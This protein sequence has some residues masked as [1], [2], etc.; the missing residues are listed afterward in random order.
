MTNSLPYAQD[1][2]HAL[3]SAGVEKGYD[4]RLSQADKVLANLRQA[5]QRGEVPLFALPGRR[6]DI[7][8]AMAIVETLK[9]DTSDL[10]I[11][12]TGGSGLSGQALAQL[13]GWGTPGYRPVEGAPHIHF[14][15]NLDAV[16]MAQAL[17]QMDLRTTRFLAISK[18]GGTAETLMQVLT[19]MSALEA[20]GGGKY[21]KHHFAVLTESAGDGG[22]NPLR[23]LAQAYDFP[24]LDH[25]PEIGG[26]YAVLSNVGMVPALLFGL[27]PQALRAGAGTVLASLLDGTSARDLAPA[28]GAALSL[29]LAEEAG[30]TATIIT[31]YADRLSKFTY[32]V[33]QLWAESLGKQGKGTL[34]VAGLGP[35]DQHSQ[36]QLYLD[37]PRDKFFTILTVADRASCPTVDET[38]ARAAGMADFAGRTMDE[39]VN[40]EAKATTDTLAARGCP[41]RSLTLPRLDEQSLGALFMHFML[42]TVI[43]AGLMNVDP[44]NQPAVE[45]AK[46]LAKKYLSEGAR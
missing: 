29:T 8:P 10:V 36:V 42:E 5:H 7:E 25:D 16:T 40:A 43:A 24:T 1:L 30:I 44:Y 33:R 3:G 9:K 12:G 18:S 20:A 32:W 4:K 23:K 2:S 19:A 46:I 27:D 39:L 31:A 21:I 6:K 41:V 28:A 14:F 11:L 35:V 37:G 22:G 17:G 15:D 26:R 45:E 38:F 34:P 13:T